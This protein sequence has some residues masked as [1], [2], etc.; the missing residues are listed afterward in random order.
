MSDNDHYTY[1]V[2]W[3][4]RDEEF[5]GTCAEFPSLSWMDET[6][7]GAL[8]GVRQ[9]VHDVLKDMRESGEETPL[10]LADKTYSGNFV[11]RIPPDLHKKLAIR[12]TECRLSLNRFIN[13][14]LA[15]IV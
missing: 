5:V 2:T 10:P 4:S 9:L 1:R 7:E 12:A 3:S 13:Y 8:R 11:L 15:L 14:H 6:Q